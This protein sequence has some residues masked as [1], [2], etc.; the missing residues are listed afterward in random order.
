MSEPGSRRGEKTREAILTAA[1]SVFA[2]HGFDGARIDTIAEVS[3][4]NK[5]LIFRYFGDKFGLYAEVLKRVDRGM[6]E[7]QARLA[8]VLEDET[9]VSDVQRFRAFLETG[10]GALFDYLL[11]HPN[12]MRMLTWEMAEGWQT[13]AKIT[14]LLKIDD[15][16]QFATLF[17]PMQSAGLLRSGLNPVLQLTMIMQICQSYLTSLPLYQM[18][19]PG[20]DISSANA[21]S[22]AREYIIDFVINGIMVDPSETTL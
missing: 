4:Y 13:Y 1:E 3:G 19:L 10:I 16:N 20:E 14:Q 11:E 18:M 12:F 2:E 6:N 8:P 21:L 17:Q 5:T 9:I 7:L 15:I 22:H